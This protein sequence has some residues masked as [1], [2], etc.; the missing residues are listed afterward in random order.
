MANN[1]TLIPKVEEKK[2][3]TRDLIESSVL[4]YDYYVMLVLSTIIVSL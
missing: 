2:Q 3:R 1:D 4:D